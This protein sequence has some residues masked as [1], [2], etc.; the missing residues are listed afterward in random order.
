MKNPTY[1][2]VKVPEQKALTALAQKAKGI[3]DSLCGVGDST[4][5]LFEPSRGHHS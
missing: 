2:E 1:M 5:G 3:G 4:Y